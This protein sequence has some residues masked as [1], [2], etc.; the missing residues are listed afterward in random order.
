MHELKE[1][2]KIGSGN[3]EK[4]RHNE[5]RNFQLSFTIFTVKD[6]FKHTKCSVQKI[7]LITGRRSNDSKFA[8]NT[9]SA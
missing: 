9:F 8:I 3:Q 4:D 2:V 7:G 1:T 6:N 5:N